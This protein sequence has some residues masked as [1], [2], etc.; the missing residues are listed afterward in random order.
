MHLHRLIAII[1]RLLGRDRAFARCSVASRTWLR[2]V[3]FLFA[4]SAAHS[5]SASVLVTGDVTPSDN[6]F[7]L[8]VNEGLP[9]DGNFVNPFEAV[10]RQTYYEG[11]HLDNVVADLTDD[12]NENIT[13]I[14]VGVSA[15]GTLLISGESAL[16]DQNLI[17]GDQGMRGGVDALGHRCRPHHR[18]RLV[19]QQR[20][21][22]YPAR[23]A[24]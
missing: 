8:N 23:P 13:D 18:V 11:I 12:T 21:I 17:I 14:I 16:R 10:D 2:L 6:P 4:I 9:S 3:L 19:V 24:G 5:A 1:R 22:D 15:S 20:S 7:T